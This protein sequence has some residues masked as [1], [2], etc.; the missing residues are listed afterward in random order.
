MGLTNEIR[1]GVA[2]DFVGAVANVEGKPRL[3]RDHV[4]RAGLGW[5]QW[6]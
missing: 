1:D 3:G 6:S 2:A 5:I 4:G